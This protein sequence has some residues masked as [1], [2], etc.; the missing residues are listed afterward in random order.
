MIAGAS[1]ALLSAGCA[2]LPTA[3][4]AQLDRA[5]FAAIDGAIGTV[6]AARGMPGAVF[7]LERKGDFYQRAYGR[8][9]YDAGYQARDDEARGER[10][11]ARRSLEVKQSEVARLE[12]ELAKLR[13]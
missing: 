6:I 11:R 13:R 3:P 10:E 8:L 7:H 2:P 12:I 5:R 1:L 9:S 4:G